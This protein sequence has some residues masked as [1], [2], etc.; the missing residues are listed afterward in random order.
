MSRKQGTPIDAC[1]VYSNQT[2]WAD[3]IQSLQGRLSASVNRCFSLQDRLFAVIHTHTHTLRVGLLVLH[4]APPQVADRGT[5]IRYYGYQ[6]NQ[7]PGVD[8]N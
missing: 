6:G 1:P 8:Q 7:I 4:R 5:P 3:Y 2:L